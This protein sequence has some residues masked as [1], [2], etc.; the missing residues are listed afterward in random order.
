MLGS[1]I[2]RTAL[3]RYFSLGKMVAVVGK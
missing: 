1:Q 3:P 2:G